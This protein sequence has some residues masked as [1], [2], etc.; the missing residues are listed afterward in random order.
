[1]VC[2][3]YPLKHLGYP[4]SELN[5]TETIDYVDSLSTLKTIVDV[6]RKNGSDWSVVGADIN[7]GCRAD[8]ADLYAELSKHISEA[9]GWTR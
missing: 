6:F 9:I 2:K 3:N 5:S 8:E 1:M 4:Y 7:A